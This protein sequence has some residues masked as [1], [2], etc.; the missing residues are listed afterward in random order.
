MVTLIKTHMG[1]VSERNMQKKTTLP[2]NTRHD[3]KTMNLKY[4]IKSEHSQCV[5]KQSLNEL[6]GVSMCA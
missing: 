5:I 4:S 6:L 1:S 2:L 3:S